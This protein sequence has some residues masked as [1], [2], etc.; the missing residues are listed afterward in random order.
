MM[1]ESCFPLATC[2]SIVILASSNCGDDGSFH[3]SALARVELFSRKIPANVSES[4]LVHKLGQHAR[5]VSRTLPEA[6]ESN[7]EIWSKEGKNNRC[8]KP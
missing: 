7:P 8:F 1:H 6:V 3:G 4:W 5:M 2:A